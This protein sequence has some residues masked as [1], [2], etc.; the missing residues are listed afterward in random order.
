MIKT[1]VD[2]VK[3]LAQ[4]R[5]IAIDYDA[6]DTAEI[7]INCD[8]GRIVQVIVNLLSNAL[9][10]S[11]QGSSVE[12]A[13]KI[14]PKFVEFSVLDRGPGIPDDKLALIFERFHQVRSA[15]HPGGTGLGLAICKAIVE[16]HGGSIGVNAASGEDNGPAPQQT[17]TADGALSKGSR[18]WFRLPALSN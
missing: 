5:N 18:F 4:R 16:Q 11:P 6:K 10:F 7:I 2:T 3:E 15:G 1:S 14:L 17:G 8:S 12:I 9:K 13:V